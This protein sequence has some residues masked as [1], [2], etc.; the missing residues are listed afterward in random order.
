VRYGADSSW[1]QR[2]VT[3]SGDCTNGYFGIDPLPGIVKRCELQATSVASGLANG[4]FEMP[5]VGAGGYRYRTSGATWSFDDGSGITA[6]ASP[7]TSGNAAAPDGVQSAFIQLAGKATQSF[8]LNAGTYTLSF[9][10]AQRGNYGSGHQSVRVS[11][12]GT[13]IGTFQPS[14]TNWSLSPSYAFTVAAGTHTLEL[15][16]VGS[17]GSDY[18]AFVDT[19]TVAPVTGAPFANGSFEMP[20]L[21]G[22]GYSYNTAGATWTFAGASGMTVNS[23]AFTSGNPN[24]P[25]GTQS[26]FLQNAGVATQTFTLAAGSY[27]LTFRA[28]QRG[29]YQIGTQ[30]V[31]ASVN[32]TPVGTFQPPGTAYAQS[33]SYAFTVAAGTHTLELAG[34][35]SGGSDFTAFVDGVAITIAPSS[36]LADG[37][38]ESPALAAGAYSYNAAGGSWAFTGESG[39]TTNANPF[40]SGNPNAPDGAQSAFIQRSGVVTQAVTLAAGSYSLRFRAA[41]RGNWQSGAQS[42][43]T[44]VSG[45]VV[46]TFQPPD[47]AYAQS[48]S[49][50]FTVSAGTHVIEFAGVGSGGSDYTAFVDLVTLEAAA[51]APTT[52]ALTS[53]ANPAGVGQS[54]LLTATVSGAGPTGNVTFRDGSATIGTGSVTSGSA[55]VTTTFATPGNKSLTAVYVGDANNA[56]STSTALAQR[57]RRQPSATR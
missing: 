45:R 49:Y 41:Q 54:V 1:I 55:S 21:G 35:G 23:S 50:S 38:F 30:A 34:V 47:T 22:G 48:P 56:A 37:S 26:A 12:D 52:T 29:N 32:G 3:T 46:G 18:T 40:T 5:S 17:G 7:F 14:G 57:S 6:N 4:S 31:R 2:S 27:N 51:A 8:T 20:A 15:A 33:P 36:G 28:A 39:V 43:R 42:V 24:A 11:I 13:A 9:R 19:V 25:D 10:A 16:G 53:S 44:S